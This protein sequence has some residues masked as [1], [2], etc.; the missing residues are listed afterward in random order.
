MD[1]RFDA[2][3]PTP[4][5]LQIVRAVRQQMASGQLRPGDPLPTVRDLARQLDLNQNTVFRAYAV[6]RDEGLVEARASL[7]T[8]VAPSARAEA[9]QAAREAELRLLA[10][11]FISQAVSHGFSLPEVEAA[12]QGQRSRWQEQGTAAGR[13]SVMPTSLLGL[14]SDDLCLELL[15][16]QFQQLHP[17]QP[18]SFVPVGSL[19]G[20]LALVRGEVHFAGAHLYD[21]DAD[22][23]NVPF[24]RELAPCREYALV[25]LAHRTQGLLV[26]KGNPK[27]VFS[28]RD[29]TRPGIRM[30]NRQRGSG[31]RALLDQLLHRE[32]LEATAISGYDREERTHLGVAAA[33]AGGAADVG[34]GI[35]AVARSFDL[36]FVPLSLERYELVLQARDP[37]LALFQ[38]AIAR[39]EFRQAAEALGGYDVTESGAVRY[40]A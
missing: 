18:I 5:Y 10:S 31:T 11:R 7:G 20:L 19:A 26:A 8:R 22:D 35:Q 24:L 6:L 30:V 1:I 29:L 34:P 15:I 28:V 38:Q 36:D 25:T 14:G 33:V 4:I 32:D 12:F 3:D 23:Y 9:V 2:Q 17:E 16:A 37:A 13:L 40:V 21:P 39:P 27:G